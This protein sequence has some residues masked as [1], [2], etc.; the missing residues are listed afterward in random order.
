MKALRGTYKALGKN[1]NKFIGS[2]EALLLR[3][4][5][6]QHPK[7]FHGIVD[8]NNLLSVKFCRSIG[9]YDLE[10]TGREFV[11]RKG[12]KGECY[13]KI[14][15]RK[16][17]LEN[18]PILADEMGAFGS[19]TSDSTRAVVLEET[20]RFVFCVFSFD[21]REELEAQIK[22]IEEMLVGVLGCSL[23]GFC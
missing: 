23:D 9:T 19:P 3:A 20:R 12:K 21:G 10:K 7:S 6:G 15:G 5:K 2:N 17:D 22:E 16:L 11:F 4:A 14:N 1:P 18:L 13:D 8:V